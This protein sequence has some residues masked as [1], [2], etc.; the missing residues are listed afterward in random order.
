MNGEGLLLKQVIGKS[1]CDKQLLA[2]ST[3]VA[4][5]IRHS[6]VKPTESRL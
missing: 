3:A 6:G 4:H 5:Y 1:S 2:L